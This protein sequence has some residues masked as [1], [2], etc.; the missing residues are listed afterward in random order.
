MDVNVSSSCHVADGKWEL[1]VY[2]DVSV[3]RMDPISLWFL[4]HRRSARKHVFGGSPWFSGTS[5]TTFPRLLLPLVTDLN[6]PSLMK[7]SIDFSAAS[8]SLVDLS[9]Y[10]DYQNHMMN[11]V[12][13]HSIYTYI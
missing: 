5:L 12:T 1:L 4:H 6:L 3:E 9:V 8:S 7:G 10:E 13:K 2:A 11:F